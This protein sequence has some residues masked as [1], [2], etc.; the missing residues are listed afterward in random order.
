[1]ENTPGK[2]YAAIISIM[3]DVGSIPKNKFNRNQEFHYR[4]VD[5]VMNALSPAFI[6]HKVFAVPEMIDQTR[7]ERKTTSGG[8]LTYSVCRMKYTFYAA[9]DASSVSVIVVGEGM[10]SGDKASNKAMA[11]AFKYACF[12]LFCIPTEEIID[13]D[14]QTP[15]WDAE[16]ITKSQ[17]SE[18]KKWLKETG[19]GYK[20]F[21]INYRIQTLDELNINQYQDALRKFEKMLP[22]P[23]TEGE[24]KHITEEMTENDSDLPFN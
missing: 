16:R 5:D 13:P 2:I 18:I 23:I 14:S 20:D 1:M 21:L 6:K 3:E 7:S 9:E 15:Q 11:V 8:T 17:V 22:P 24:L 12:Q 4:G 10:D 19:V